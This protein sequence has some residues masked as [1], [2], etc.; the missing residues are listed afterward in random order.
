M[1]KKLLAVSL[2]GIL[3]LSSSSFAAITEKMN[4]SK[5]NLQQS[6][7]QTIEYNF[8]NDLQG[9]QAGFADLPAE[10]DVYD[11][12][13]LDYDYKKIPVANNE[14]M[15]AYL[16][17]NNHSDDLFMYITKNIAEDIELK[18]NTEYEIELSFK[19]ATNEA[20]SMMGVGGAPGE[21][22]FVK[23]G[24]VGKKPCPIVDDSNYYR[25]NIDKGNQSVG[26]S[27]LPLLGNIAKDN[28]SLDRSYAYK[29]F[30][31]KC[32]VKTDSKGNAYIVIGLDSGYE[33]ITKV[34]F[35]D[36]VL[37]VTMV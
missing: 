7:T 24:V 35:D 13:E 29:N 33:G 27:E 25:M 30:S 12:Y 20:E 3:A 21:S 32:K 11:F 22:V 23:G 16:A 36:I 2:A 28:G 34:Y 31:T 10:K 19:I 37:K 8:N 4:I 14:S 9:F 17:G 26:G 6:I 18:P 5:Y 15:G 1:K